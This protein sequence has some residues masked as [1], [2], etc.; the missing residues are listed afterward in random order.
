MKWESQWKSRHLPAPETSEESFLFPKEMCLF[1]FL[2]SRSILCF[3]TF[4]GDKGTESMA[5]P[6]PTRKSEARLASQPV[7][8]TP[9]LDPS[10]TF[11]EKKARL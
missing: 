1:L 9:N 7:L 5:L 6:L 10:T 3:S 4:G 11:A 2:S 8:L